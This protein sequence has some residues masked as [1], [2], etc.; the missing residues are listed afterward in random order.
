MRTLVPILTIALAAC[1]AERDPALD[2]P[3]LIT[4][5]IPL[6]AQVA[7][8]DG[9]L[10][11]V[12][13]V[14]VA[15]AT[16]A[17]HTVGVGRD[18]IWASPTFKRDRLLVI[19]RGEEALARGQ[20]DEDPMLWNIDVANPDTPPV[21]YDI[22]SPFDR[23]AVSTDGKLAVAHFSEAGPDAQGFFRNPNELAFVDLTRPPG[24][25]NP[26][27]KT[28]RSFSS[29]PT[30]IVLS[31]PMTIPGAADATPR[32]F[33]FVLAQ[34]R[35]SVVDATYPT[36]DEVTIRLDQAGASVLPREVVFAPNTA[37]AYV[38]SD[39]A[40][41]VL[42]VLIGNDPPPA[43]QADAND[44]RPVL[45]ELGAGGGPADVAVYDD[46]DGR[47]FILAAT[48]GTREVVV[49]D[50]D[51]AEFVRVATPDPVDRI[52]LFPADP[53]VPARKAVLASIGARL[54]RVQVLDLEGIDEDLIPRSVTTIEVGEP[55]MAIEPVPGRELAM[56]V[57]DDQRTVL[58]L[59][60]VAY[61]SVSPLQGV[62]RLDDYAFTSSG[63]YLVAATPSLARLGYLDL[64]NLHPT[65]LRLDDV[66]A[67]LFALPDGKLFVDHGDPL[68][69]ATIIPSPEASRDD[70]VVLSGFLL[71][72]LLEE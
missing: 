70:S 24:P 47:R 37:T 28:L 59:L 54:S 57:H 38:R 12:V 52:V 27:L 72:G 19:T 34:N 49:I 6:Q 33:A 35:I 44:F 40:R 23:L 32:V 30:A 15:E 69:R 17:V 25:D 20:V 41:D 31:P 58:G 10:D 8:V 53:D 60:D 64:D 63:K 61:G 67:R 29:T 45:A 14:D 13:L 48:P 2:R 42:E 39:G 46:V 11:R 21:G 9:A 1:A 71:A 3:R 26:V 68:G 36:H 65:D 18:P 55:V 7:Y 43:D 50:A 56:L 22:G 4:G 66:P 5:P 16:P 51:T 62:G